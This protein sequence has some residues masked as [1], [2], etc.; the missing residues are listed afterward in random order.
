M[1]YNKEIGLKNGIQKSNELYDRA[2]NVIGSGTNTFS[3][4]P[5]VFPDGVAPKFLDKQDGCH[6]WDVD[7]NRFIDMVMGCGPVTLGHNHPVINNAIIDQMDK[8]GILYSMLNPLEVEVA[9]KLIDVIDCAEMVKFSKNGSDVCAASVKLARHVTGRDMIFQWGYHGFQDWYIGT[10]DRNAGVPQVVRD[11]TLSFDYEDTDK[12]REMFQKYKGKV[13]AVVMEPVIGQRHMCSHCFDFNTGKYRQHPVK[14]FQA[15]EKDPNMHILKEIKEIA[16][17]YGALLIFDEMISGFR[18]SM[19]GAGK[20]FGVTPDLATFGK[21]ITNGM[22]LG[23]LVGKKEYMQHFDKVFLSSTYAPEALTLAAASA[24]IDFYNKHDVIKDFWKK[25]DYLDY[26]FQKVIDEHDLAKN[27]SLAGY[28]VRMMVNTH[29]DDGLQDPKLASLYQQ[30]MFRNGV[31]CFAGV[32]MLSYSLTDKDLSAIVEAF[33]KTC[34]V[35]KEAVASAKPI[36]SFLECTPGA[37]VFKG[38][39][40]RNAVSN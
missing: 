15:C 1:S 8:G 19:G 38:L 30:E 9:E 11:L 22:P 35:I 3:R 23:V 6:T 2:K 20:Y 5:G 14:S 29:G 25:G 32:L 17:E 34:K 12:L 36:D 39:R 28:S 4:A 33:D 37:P 40:E 31:L 16:H 21:G 27:V 24:N 26:N 18:F 13:A 7:G 10:T